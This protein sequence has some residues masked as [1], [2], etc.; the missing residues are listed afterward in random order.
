MKG[1]SRACFLY[2]GPVQSLV[3]VRSRNSR[4]P[5]GT[6]S[7]HQLMMTIND[8]VALVLHMKVYKA[9]SQLLSFHITS[10]L[11]LR[12]KLD[13]TDKIMESQGVAQGRVRAHRA[14][15]SW[16]HP[17][18]PCYQWAEIGGRGPGCDGDKGPR[19]EAWVWRYSKTG[20]ELQLKG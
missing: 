10:L 12:E 11:G 9:W 5:Q 19:G 6:V 3:R 15:L 17:G 7:S 2:S 16:T 14:F 4:R 13:F 18:R 1:I 20:E 8:Q